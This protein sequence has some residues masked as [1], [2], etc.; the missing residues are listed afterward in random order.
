[1]GDVNKLFVFKSLLTK[2]SNALPLHL[3][4][5]FPPIIWIFT[6][7]DGIESSLPFRIFST[8]T[9]VLLG[10]LIIR[11]NFDS[12]PRLIRWLKPSKVSLYRILLSIFEFERQNIAGCF[13]QTFHFNIELIQCKAWFLQFSQWPCRIGATIQIFWQYYKHVLSNIW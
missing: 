1:M 10:P 9:Y 6:E 12:I 5:T 3:S 2:P 4:Q 8:L 7:G 11:R 13:K